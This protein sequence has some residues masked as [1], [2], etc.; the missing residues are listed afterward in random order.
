MRGRGVLMA[1]VLRVDDTTTSTGRLADAIKRGTTVFSLYGTGASAFQLVPEIAGK[2]KSLTVF[3][4][5]PPW[6]FP[7]P[8]YHADVPDGKKWVL[9][10]VPFYDKWYRFWLLW[11]A[12]DGLLPA[13]RA[14][15]D[16][17]GPATAISEPNHVFREMVAGMLAEQAQG[18]PDLI[19]KII[20]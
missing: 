18:R 13:V 9:E 3:Q 20:P 10:S 11:M 15:P 1:P 16:W 7:T 14:D 19:D 6:I 8:N 5:T 17:K 12:T 2:V 4:R